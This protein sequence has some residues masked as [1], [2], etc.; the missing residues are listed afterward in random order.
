MNRRQSVS[1]SSLALFLAMAP[2]VLASNTWYVDGVSGSDSNS[3]VSP[4]IACKTIWHAISLASSGDSI[5]VASATYA[6]SLTI[7]KSLTIL[8]SGAATTI[9]QSGNFVVTPVVTISSTT[10]VTLQGLPSAMA[11]PPLA[12]ASTTE[13]R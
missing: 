4:E 5:I 2:T 3:C 12:A 9:I 11:R 13:G 7:G 10:A 1:F 6:E 8:G